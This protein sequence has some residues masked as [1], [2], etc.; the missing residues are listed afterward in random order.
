MFLSGRKGMGNKFTLI[1]IIMIIAVIYILR[2][3]SPQK[4][5]IYP[6]TIHYYDLEYEYAETVKSWPVMFVRKKPVSEEGYII[7]TRRG[8]DMQEEIYIYEGHR[9][10]RRYKV[11]KE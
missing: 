3:A 5:E 2:P 6:D 10:Y 11:L 1:S 9:E 8:T 4:E 7:L